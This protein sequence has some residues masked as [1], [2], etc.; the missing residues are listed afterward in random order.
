MVSVLR[1]H[2]AL[3]GRKPN[4]VELV[5]MTDPLLFPISHLNG[6]VHAQ[7]QT[8]SSGSLQVPALPGNGTECHPECL[9]EAAGCGRHTPGKNADL[10]VP[11]L[12]ETSHHVLAHTS[13]L[14]TPHPPGWVSPQSTA[15]A[16]GTACRAPNVHLGLLSAPALGLPPHPSFL[17]L[18]T[19]ARHQGSLCTGNHVHWMPSALNATWGTE[20]TVRQVTGPPVPLLPLL[21][22][23]IT[24]VGRTKEACVLQCSEV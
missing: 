23:C 8:S 11:S 6:L 10:R 20:H 17:L 13:E 18:A 3:G 14:C 24:C 12:P 9:L 16:G 4:L 5:F 22:P 21:W 19:L 2:R 7:V 1:Q 15:G